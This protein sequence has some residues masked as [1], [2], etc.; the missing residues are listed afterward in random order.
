[1]ASASSVENIVSV[2][3][4]PLL[5]LL[6]FASGVIRRD[7]NLWLFGSWDGRRYAD[8]AAALFRYTPEPLPAAVRRVWISRRRH[9]VHGL[10]SQGFRAYH[11][12][13]PI[14]FW[15]CLRAA[16][17]IC[18]GYLKD[19]NFWTSRGAVQVA[20]QHGPGGFKRIERDIRIPGHR[21]NQLFHGNWVERAFWSVLIP[22]HLVRP[23]LVICASEQQAREAATAYAVAERHIVITGLPRN[24][25]ICD[26][27]PFPPGLAPLL[28]TI[29][30]LQ[31]DGRRVYLHM[32]TL[33]ETYPSPFPAAWRQLDSVLEQEHVTVIAHQ[34]FA[35]RDDAGADTAVSEHI[36][37]VA[38]H[39][40]LY[41]LFS[42]VDGL[43]TD[44]SSAAFDYLLTDRPV[45][46]F[47]PDYDRFLATSRD[48]RLSF[49]D[50]ACGPV[51]K[52]APELQTV[53]QSSPR[54]DVNRRKTLRARFHAYS[55]GASRE[56]VYGAILA[57][58]SPPVTTASMQA[59]S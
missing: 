16:V 22:W 1:M 3:L 14:G 12:F 32:P 26:P 29:R 57:R 53:L 37:C 38:A 34:H 28:E 6:Y 10:R 15:Y 58:M 27:G 54:I 11:A 20:L 35:Q 24:D 17:Y 8:N 13:S 59:A 47:I 48:L 43:I 19:I 2:L 45:I 41:P 36:V 51:A 42:H 56:R 33:R 4:R 49:D 40:D 55:D 52:T 44:F 5:F 30:D 39:V 7:P 25:E 9:I 18:D 46:H 31:R 23:D 50:C 21:L